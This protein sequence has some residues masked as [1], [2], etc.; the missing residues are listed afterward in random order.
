LIRHLQSIDQDGAK[1]GHYV[2]AS[3]WFQIAAIWR[4]AGFSIKRFAV[5]KR[6]H[7]GRVAGVFDG[8]ST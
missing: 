8:S 4:S 7:P 5:R 6:E 1:V 3:L 2:P